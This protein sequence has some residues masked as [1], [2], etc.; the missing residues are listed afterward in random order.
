MPNDQISARQ[1]RM[2]LFAALL[3]PAIQVLPGQ[4]AALAG[5]GSWLSAL[6]A[7]PLMVLLCLAL[8]SLNQALLPNQGLASM[9]RK[10]LGP[11]LGSMVLGAYL[12]WG[13]VLL[14]AD[15]RRYA[16]RFLSTS[17]R[18]APL[19]LFIIIL[20]LAALWVARG[21]LS[22]LARL[23]EMVCLALAIALGLMLFFGLFQIRAAHVFPLW[24]QDLPS[25]GAACLPVLAVLG[26]SVFGSFLGGGGT[27]GKGKWVK[28]AAV[29]CGVL[30]LLQVVCLGCLG[31]A[32]TLRTDAPF[33]MV[34][35]GIGVQ[36]A[37]ERVESVIIALWVLSDLSLLCLILFACRNIIQTIFPRA[38]ARAWTAA[39]A[40]AAVLVALFCFPDGYILSDFMEGVVTLGNLVF[41][42]VL[43]LL[44]WAIAAA[45]GM[46]RRGYSG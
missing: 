2:L 9:I 30:T 31:S 38:N 11:V 40:G 18:N 23:G 43:P 24:I 35:K 33:F 4:T 32:L 39:P 1:L 46:L 28:W 15:A 7:L 26:Y 25:I 45:R 19:V 27:S 22:A 36:G 13:V 8:H 41:G 12:L 17:Y 44:I 5:R 14:G 16:L 6:P 10:A 37:F 42:F 29:V 21:P 3:S 20:L 34:V